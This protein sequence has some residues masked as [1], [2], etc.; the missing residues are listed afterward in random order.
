MTTQLTAR[1]REQAYKAASARQH[2][3]MAE[4]QQAAIR[5]GRPAANRAQYVWLASIDAHT[6]A[7]K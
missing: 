1:E 5:G 3:R 4:W 2:A 7:N 6:T